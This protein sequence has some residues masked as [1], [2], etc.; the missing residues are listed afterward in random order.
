MPHHH[1]TA[2]YGTTFFHTYFTSTSPRQK[3]LS[4][5]PSL[6]REF[7]AES[8]QWQYNGVS[9]EMFS[10]LVSKPL[11]SSYVL[12]VLCGGWAMSNEHQGAP[13][14]QRSIPRQE[15]FSSHCNSRSFWAPW[16]RVGM[17]PSASAK[18]G[19]YLHP[20]A[21]PHSLSNVWTNWGINLIL[22]LVGK[23]WEMN[24]CQPRVYFQLCL[25]GSVSHPKRSAPLSNKVY[26][27]RL[28]F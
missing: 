19:F 20:T 7:E 4:D 21:L 13:S 26:D 5:L 2:L 15:L 17:L 6:P 28:D 25:I 12:W 22:M 24:F 9:K 1:Y 23:K 27:N 18:A 10:H 14:T 3:T 11:L 16:K 8:E